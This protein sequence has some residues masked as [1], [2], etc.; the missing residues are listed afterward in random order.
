MLLLR[1]AA[2]FLRRGLKDLYLQMGTDTS[3][4][5]LPIHKLVVILGEENCN[6]IL[7]AHI[8]TGYDLI[9]KLG[10]KSKA[11]SQGIFG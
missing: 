4:R 9:S 7:K 2:T 10:R 5:Y 3:V 1:Y 6:N 8:A 11:L